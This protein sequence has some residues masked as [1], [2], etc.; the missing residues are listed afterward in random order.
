MWVPA[1][2]AFFF[3]LAFGFSSSITFSSSLSLISAGDESKTAT[4]AVLSAVFSC[5]SNPVMTTSCSFYFLPFP[6]PLPLAGIF[7]SSFYGDK[8][9]LPMEL[10]ILC[11]N[12]K[13]YKSFYS[14][15]VNESSSASWIAPSPPLDKPTLFIDMSLALLCY[16]SFSNSSYISFSIYARIAAF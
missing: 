3:P 1:A 2:A 15:W 11:A 14:C 8:V 6:F 7:T 9:K 5:F 4:S 10:A 13:L 16:S 12:A